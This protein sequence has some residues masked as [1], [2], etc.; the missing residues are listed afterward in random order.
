MTP[1]IAVVDEERRMR[2]ILAMYL[3]RQDYDWDVFENAEL[4][5]TL[6]RALERTRLVRQNGP[7]GPGSDG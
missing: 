6:E 5:A 4:P 3:R 2:K 7:L 1:R